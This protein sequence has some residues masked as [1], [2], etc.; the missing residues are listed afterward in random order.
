M[1]R[2]H[3]GHQ[4]GGELLEGDGS[5]FR[6]CVTAY[7]EV[8]ACGAW[9]DVGLKGGVNRPGLGWLEAPDLGNEDGVMP[10]EIKPGRPVDAS[11]LRGGEGRRCGWFVS[12]A[13]SWALNMGRSSGSL[14][15]LG[16]E[17]GLQ[18]APSTYYAAKRRQVAP[19][20]RAIRDAVMM[21]VLAVLWVANRKVYG[22]HKLWKAARRAGHD[23]R[24]DQVTGSCAS[25][26]SQGVSRR[27]KVFTTRP[28][29][30]AVRATD[31]V[32]RNFTAT[33]PIQLWVTDLTPHPN[34]P[35]QVRRVGP[36]KDCQPGRRRPLPVT[37]GGAGSSRTD[38]AR[39]PS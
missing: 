6:D 22:A 17:S 37:Q 13:G 3:S 24:R 23:I 26:G 38:Q 35:S 9:H 21:Q 2:I 29:P 28:D 39:M 12:C 15:S 5:C 20:A 27:R 18:M 10:N 7:V 16:T 8:L 34:P 11:V 30:D 33:A 1:W 14:T 25:W 31:L 36:P 4:L 32:K 19:S